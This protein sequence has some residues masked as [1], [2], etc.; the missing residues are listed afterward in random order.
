MLAGVPTGHRGDPVEDHRAA[1]A[2]VAA[3]SPTVDDV[4]TALARLAH[5]RNDI[6]R[7]ERELIGAA[8]DLHVTWPDIAT[9]LGLG[10]RQAA[11]QRWLRLRGA[12]SRDPDRVREGRREQRIVDAA[13]GEELSQLRAAAV[14]AHRRI[15]ADH[16]WDDRHDRAAL[17][18]A[19]LAAAT[20]APPGALYSLCANAL[21]DLAAM[22]VVR[23]SPATAAAV[24]RLR[25]AATTVRTL[26]RRA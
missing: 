19:T 5:I 21:D 13:Y 25:E 2:V 22:A 23:L 15:E 8:R 12:P 26:S 24:R 10:S 14:E 7:I 17:A 3:A 11:E 18:R 16:G 6:D 9:A 20:T 1:A 4:M